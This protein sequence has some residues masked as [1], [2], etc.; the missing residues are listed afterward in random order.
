MKN[1]P[2]SVIAELR[3]LQEKF[4]RYVSKTI[5]PVLFL[6]PGT[7]TMKVFPEL[8]LHIQTVKQAHM[9]GQ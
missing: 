1:V 7:V 3:Q 8:L 9:T 6:M 2:E 5:C 4:V